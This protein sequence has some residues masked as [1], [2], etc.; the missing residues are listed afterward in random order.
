[1][2]GIPWHDTLGAAR[3]AAMASG[4]LMLT[5]LHAPG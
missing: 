2:A 4:R 1:M 5:Y 3:E